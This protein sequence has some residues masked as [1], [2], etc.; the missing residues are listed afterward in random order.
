MYA[1]DSIA[2]LRN[3]GINFERH[4]QDG[5]EPNTFAYMLITSG[6]VLDTQPRV[7]WITFH[8]GYD[9]CYLLK[10][11]LIIQYQGLWFRT[12]IYFRMILN[13][14]DSHTTE[15]DK[16]YLSRRIMMSRPR[17]NP[18]KRSQKIFRPRNFLKSPFQAFL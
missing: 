13:F 17:E 15:L 9:F 1:E 14:W 5:I 12:L 2:L 6:V 18:K 10:V 8:S 3:C 4:K 16:R 11:I 7:N